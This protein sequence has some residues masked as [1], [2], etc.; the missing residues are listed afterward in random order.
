MRTA[1]TETVRALKRALRGHPS[2]RAF[3]RTTGAQPGDISDCLHGKPMKAARENRLRAA[4]GLAP[5]AY[6]TVELMDNQRVVSVT[7]PRPTRRRAATMTADEAIRADR[8]A[9]T[10]G[11]RSW[12]AYAVATL[13]REDSVEPLYTGQAQRNPANTGD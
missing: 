10:A 9:R 11:Y 2:H 7:P 5:L 3:A 1:T 6:Q 13:L 4:L 8:I 12:G